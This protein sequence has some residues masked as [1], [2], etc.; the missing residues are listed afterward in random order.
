MIFD[1]CVF[2]IADSEGALQT[3][4]TFASL[5]FHIHIHKIRALSQM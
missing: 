5:V 3:V 4:A 2:N 1:Y